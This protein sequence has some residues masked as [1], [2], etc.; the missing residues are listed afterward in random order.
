MSAYVYSDPIICFF[1]LM[2]FIYIFYWHCMI[3]FHIKQFCP[4][5]WKSRLFAILFIKLLELIYIFFFIVYNWLFVNIDASFKKCTSV[6]DRVTV[7]VLTECL[8]SN[9]ID[10]WTKCACETDA[11]RRW[12]S[13][14]LIIIGFF[15]N[16]NFWQNESSDH[17]T[18]MPRL[19]SCLDK[20]SLLNNQTIWLPIHRYMPNMQKFSNFFDQVILFARQNDPILYFKIFSLVF[21]YFISFFPEFV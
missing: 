18:S 19:R 2:N 16:Q 21:S 14:V 8:N 4:T 6:A 20:S 7:R 9:C 1:D 12:L 11:N 17:T 15:W 13:E 10:Y 3:F 5:L